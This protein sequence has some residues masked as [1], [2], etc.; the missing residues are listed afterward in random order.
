MDVSHAS[1]QQLR[2]NIWV[3]FATVF[4]PF[5][6]DHDGTFHF[7]GHGRLPYLPGI[8]PIRIA[9]NGVAMTCCTPRHRMEKVAPP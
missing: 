9:G 8:N 6:I 7:V 1:V 5:G 3:P 2:A 4:F